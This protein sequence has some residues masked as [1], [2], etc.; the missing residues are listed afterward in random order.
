[1]A[2]APTYQDLARMKE[3]NARI[4]EQMLQRQAVARDSEIAGES[5]KNPVLQEYMNRGLGLTPVQGLGYPTQQPN[6]ERYSQAMIS[7]AMQGQVPVEA[8]LTD[9]RVL[10][11]YRQGLMQQLQQTQQPQGLGRLM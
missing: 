1:M 4:N 3:E 7:A 11:Q 10:P 9:E 2:A 8:V 5:N 6:A